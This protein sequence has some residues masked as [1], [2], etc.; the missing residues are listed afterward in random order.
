MKVLCQFQK[1]CSFIKKN[2]NILSRTLVYFAVDN[3]MKLFFLTL[4]F[5]INK[6][7]YITTPTNTAVQICIYICNFFLILSILLSPFY[8][9]FLVFFFISNSKRVT[10]SMCMIKKSSTTNIKTYINYYFIFL[11]SYLLLVLL[12]SLLL[13]FSFFIIF[14]YIIDIT[15]K[16]NKLLLI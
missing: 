11:V 7:N 15:Y 16:Y 9:F 4:F 3:E 10:M 1:F 5:F 14:F 2:M 6:K 13:V 8:F 12:L